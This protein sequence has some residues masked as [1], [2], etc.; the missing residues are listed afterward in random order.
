MKKLLSL[1]AVVLLGI[2]TVFANPVDVNTA[3]SM[4]QKFVQT[5][6]ENVRSANLEL[7]YTFGTENEANCYVFNVDGR[8]FVVVSADDD[9]RPI[10]GFSEGETFST[11]NPERMYYLRSISRGMTAN[12]GK[13][14][15][16][17]VAEEWES[18]N[19][20]G[21]LLSYN[22][23][24]VVDMLVQTKWNQNPAP[25]NSACPVDANGPGGHAYVGCVATAMAQIMNYWKYPEHGTGTRGYNHPKYGYISANFG[26][27]T[28]DWD[29]ML[30]EYEGSY[31]PEQGNAVAT[32]SSHAGV[33][34]GMNYGGYAEKGSA[35]SSYNV[36]TA[37][38]QYFGYTNAAQYTQFSNLTTWL[39]T[40]KSGMDK[41]WPFYYSG[42]EP[43][44]DYGHAF[45]CDGYDD[46]DFF[47][48]N[49]GWAGSGDNWFIVTQMDYTDR[50][51]IINN[52]V[53]TPVYNSTPQAPSSFTAS[54]ANN[55]ALEASLSWVNPIR[56]MNNANLTTIDQM[57]VERDGQIIH[58]F[59]NA[60]P[61]AT[62]TYVDSEV[63]YYS[64]FI[65]KVYAVNNN[66]PGTNAKTTATFGP[67]C[68]WT[69]IGT[70]NNS[71]GWRGGYI[72]ARDASG[73]VVGTMTMTTNNPPLS[74][75]M[76]IGF[77]GGRVSFSWH[78][79]S[80]E[81]TSMSFKIK[82]PSGTVRYEYAAASSN[83]IPS[84]VLCAARN[85]CGSGTPA[86]GPNDAYAAINGDNVV[87]TWVGS[88]KATLGYNIYRDNVLVA[89]VYDTEYV[90]EAPEQGG[91]CYMVTMLG[92]DGE[93]EY[94]NETC[95]N[96]GDGCEP[97]TNLWF[98]LQDNNY[99][100]ITW[101]KP[102]N[103]TGLTGYYVY[104]RDGDD[105]D[106]VKIKNVG[107]SKV[108]YKE[109]VSANLQEG[110]WYSYKVTAYYKNIACTSAPFMSKYAY[111]FH[112]RYMYSTDGVEENNVQSIS[113]YPNPAKDRLT[114]K[115]DNISNVVI[116]NSLGQ[117][118]FAKTYDTE[119]AT[120]DMSG[121]D[122]GIYMV[123]ISADGT[124]VTRKIS[125]VK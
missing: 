29:N 55:T 116:F 48:F 36:P 88:T 64:S 123:R 72:E 53:P 9:F 15:D 59:E 1:A 43:G 63:P 61:G 23:G 14:A 28:Y 84:G 57:V 71:Q 89:L 6:F 46:A 100:T 51:A 44:S 124:E 77:G 39:N 11:E 52:F 50:M 4:G 22:R 99:P 45:V 109:S 102:A 13:A 115:A 110:V 80:G 42:T 79:G 12:R 96:V 47:H 87:L 104:R 114:V 119:E 107:A 69:I 26:N 21:R 19:K 24:K 62:M 56:T 35:A 40:L 27:T 86:E 5:R 68:N 70:S 30:N 66:V 85:F 2:G 106:Y 97:G 34:V 108:E 8:G 16:P 65:Y 90:D 82:D 18:L 31:T 58:V 92:D 94:S 118:V 103:A 78:P 49:W 91:H 105:A 60:T 81:V 54:V 122:A 3:K 32:L 10:I 38:M 95:V 125:V 67:T 17:R 83:N 120:I 37:I 93:S 75:Q 20:Y 101:E 41:G 121:F 117:K 73:H 98:Y 25:Y 74:A 112:V 76:P 7:V 111:E 113:V 33:A